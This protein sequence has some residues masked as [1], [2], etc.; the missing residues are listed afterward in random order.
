MNTWHSKI[1]GNGSSAFGPAVLI[2]QAFL[3]LYVGNDKGRGKAVLTRYS[4]NTDAVTVYFTPDASALAEQF[5]AVPCAQ[6]AAGEV[7]YL[8]GDR[9]SVKQFLPEP[10]IS[11][12]RSRVVTPRAYAS[13]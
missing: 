12:A 3:A 6:P 7:A 9:D 2:Q 5:D 13:M 1:I 8:L 4:A 11:R 10:M